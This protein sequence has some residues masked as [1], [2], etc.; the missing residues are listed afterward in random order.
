MTRRLWAILT[1]LL[2]SVP[3]CAS[4][5]QFPTDGTFVIGRELPP[6]PT[7]APTRTGPVRILLVR[8]ISCSGIVAHGCYI[9]ATREILIEESLPLVLRWRILRHELVHAAMHAANLKFDDP[10]EENAVA[11][12]MADQQ[13]AEM[14]SSWPR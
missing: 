8:G 13:L 9:Y 3:T 11:E 6:F 14:L 4:V 7:W 12:A 1:P 5:P 2:L 10:K